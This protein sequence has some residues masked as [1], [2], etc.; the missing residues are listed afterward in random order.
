MTDNSVSV[1]EAVQ[2]Y[3][4]RLQSMSPAITTL[5]LNCDVP[6]ILRVQEVSPGQLG[7]GPLTPPPFVD[8]DDSPTD[9]TSLGIPRVSSQKR[10]NCGNVIDLLEE[11]ATHLPDKAAEFE[12]LRLD[13]QV[14]APVAALG[15]P[16]ALSRPNRLVAELTSTEEEAACCAAT[17]SAPSASSKPGRLVAELL[18]SEA[19]ESQLQ[20]LAL[21]PLEV[22]LEAPALCTWHCKAEAPPQRP[23][24]H[25]DATVPPRRS[26]HR[27]GRSL[28][29]SLGSQAW[30]VAAPP[31]LP[32]RAA[33]S[34]S[35]EG[36]SSQRVSGLVADPALQLVPL[37]LQQEKQIQKKRA[38]RAAAESSTT[39]K[40][41]PQPMHNMQHLQPLQHGQV[42][43]QLQQVQHAPAVQPVQ[44]LQQCQ[45]MQSVPFAQQLASVQQVQSAQQAQ[46][47]L[48]QIQPAQQAQALQQTQHVQ[49]AHSMQQMQPMQ[50]VHSVQQ[51]FQSADQLQRVQQTQLGLQM[52]PMQQIQPVQQG[53]GHNEVA[54]RRLLADAELLLVL[55]PGAAY[56]KFCEANA[57]HRTST[58]SVAGCGSESG[59]AFYGMARCASVGFDVMTLCSGLPANQEERLDLGISMLESARSAG[60]F[61]QL[62]QL[63]PADPSLRSLR[64]HRQGRFAAVLGLSPAALALETTEVTVVGAAP[65]APAA[66]VAA[67]GGTPGIA[68]LAELQSKRAADVH[69]AEEVPAHDAEET[70]DNCSDAESSESSDEE[71]QQAETLNQ[72]RKRDCEDDGSEDGDSDSSS[73]S[74]SDAGTQEVATPGNQEAQPEEDDEDD[75]EGESDVDVPQGLRSSVEAFAD[76]VRS[77]FSW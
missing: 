51:Q 76:S 75:S 27:R 39:T 72:I 73:D 13:E 32:A 67:A 70:D 10:L 63:A 9:D 11:L 42:A 60:N 46:L 22:V 52:Q 31:K 3:E 55:S 28:D 49:Q 5:A 33:R 18:A 69:P 4:A 62:F 66:V 56:L 71:E 41:R 58:S 29:A 19:E 53:L 64:E 44:Q 43:S 65:V 35:P 34:S 30:P 15:T 50:T 54:Y 7:A 16:S 25:L 2:R 37:R 47:V 40:Q 45:Q 1:P 48:S 20:P 77:I 23:W 8:V 21:A 57:L 36:R 61:Q 38:L 74:E 24:Q 6:R 68:A 12:P 59:E 26:G 14:T 17:F